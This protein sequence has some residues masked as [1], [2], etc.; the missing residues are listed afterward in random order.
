MIKQEKPKAKLMTLD[1][2]E[3]DEGDDL[4]SDKLYEY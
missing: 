4:D 2:V 1:Q 3:M